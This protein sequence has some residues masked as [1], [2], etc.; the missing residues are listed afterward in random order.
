VALY[1]DGGRYQGRFRDGE[2][3]GPGRWEPKAGP[4]YDG[5]WRAGLRHGA[6]VER[7]AAGGRPAPVVFCDDA[8]APA[9]ADDEARAA[10]LAEVP[11][12]PRVPARQRR[13]AVRDAR[14]PPPP[15]SY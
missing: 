4:S 14:G 2:R 8:P 6:G 11:A 7:A 5:P 3:H 13:A 9:G 15:P 10:A 1:A 12:A